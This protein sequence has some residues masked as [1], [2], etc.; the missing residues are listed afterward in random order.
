MLKSFILI[1]GSEYYMGTVQGKP[2]YG[3]DKSLAQKVDGS[4]NIKTTIYHILCT[5]EDIHDI[6]ILTR[7]ESSMKCLSCLQVQEIANVCMNIECQER[8]LLT[9]I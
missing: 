2:Y 9:R 8:E 4:V 7:P 1:N 5:R 6:K 3:M